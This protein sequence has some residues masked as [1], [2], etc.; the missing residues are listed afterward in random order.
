MTGEIV[1][2]GAG[3]C[4]A[5]AAFALRERGFSGRVTLV[6]E[7]VHLPYERPPLS[8][9]ST[10]GPPVPQLVAARQAYDDAGIELLTGHCVTKI[11]RAAKRLV[12]SDAGSLGYD[13]LLLA[14][15]ARP[16]R[17]PNLTA[18]RQLLTLRTHGD[19]ERI[20]ARLVPGRRLVVIGGG[21]IGLELSAM[22]RQAGAEV[23]VVEGQARLLARAVPAEIAALVEAR[24]RQAGTRILLDAGVAAIDETEDE[25][26]V[27]LVDGT[28]VTGDVALLGIGAVPNTELAEAAGL[29]L[30]NGIAVDEYL[31]SSDPDIFAA[32]DCCSFP[33]ALYG[34]RRIRLESWRSAQDQGSLVAANLLGARNPVGHV[35]WFWSDQ[36]DLTLQIAGLA[37]TA[38]RTVRRELGDNAVILFHLEESGRLVAASAIGPGNTVA[39]DVRLAEMLIAARACPD[40]LALASPDIRLKSLLAA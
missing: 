32:G 29:R 18:S 30:E 26:T 25:I 38:T 24:H 40:P 17:L 21:F 19:A 34:N 22:A 35:P 3:L 8:K 12:L 11:D 4:G 14:T 28:H 20:A 23:T 6:G 37:D 36:F 33:L 27:S 31:T 16:R 15:G 39:R 7:E 2:V 9:P 1:I 10:A 5:R 13:R